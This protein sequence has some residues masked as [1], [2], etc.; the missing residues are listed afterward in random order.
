MNIKLGALQTPRIVQVEVTH[1]RHTDVPIMVVTSTRNEDEEIIH[2][3]HYVL[4]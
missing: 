3:R 1:N 4:N 2:R